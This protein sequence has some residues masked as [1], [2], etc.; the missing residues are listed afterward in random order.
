MVEQT[1][2]VSLAA[3][4]TP[5]GRYKTSGT[6]G[7]TYIEKAAFKRQ[8]QQ[9]SVLSRAAMV[10]TSKKKKCHRHQ[11]TLL[12]TLPR[13]IGLSLFSATTSDTRKYGI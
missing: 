11:Q 13:T 3:M 2:S 12:A 7:E 9:A 5:V 8:P 6:D 4:S 10:H 1:P